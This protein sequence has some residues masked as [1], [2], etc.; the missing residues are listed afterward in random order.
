LDKKSIDKK[1]CSNYGNENTKG[2]KHSIEFSKKLSTRMLG[3][4]YGVGHTVSQKSID[5]LTNPEF[6]KQRNEKLK[7]HVFSDEHRQNISNAKKGKLLSEEHKNKLKE[8]WKL[9]KLK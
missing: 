1:S 9:R 2:Y 7:N 5:H 4:N 6:I 3:N 8:A